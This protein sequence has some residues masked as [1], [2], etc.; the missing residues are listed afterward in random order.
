MNI[1]ETILKKIYQFSKESQIPMELMFFLFSTFI[2]IYF[3]FKI[4]NKDK[5]ENVLRILFSER[6]DEEFGGYVAP[7][8]KGRYQYILYFMSSFLCFI[9]SIFFLIRFIFINF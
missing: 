6:Y 8:L 3:W 9:L 1:Q 4:S 5:N 2:F 7:K